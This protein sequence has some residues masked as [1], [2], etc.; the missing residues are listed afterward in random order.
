MTTALAARPVRSCA[1]WV[2]SVSERGYDLHALAACARA[3]VQALMET[4]E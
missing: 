3:H 4:K 1:R 2:V